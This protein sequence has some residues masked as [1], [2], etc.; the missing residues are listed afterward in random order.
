MANCVRSC[1]GNCHACCIDICLFA[2]WVNPQRIINRALQVQ[3][4]LSPLI[5]KGKINPIS[6]EERRGPPSPIFLETGSRCLSLLFFRLRGFQDRP[7]PPLNLLWDRR[8][9]HTSPFFSFRRNHQF[10]FFFSFSFD[11]RCIKGGVARRTDTATWEKSL[12]SFFLFTGVQKCLF[13]DLPNVGPRGKLLVRKSETFLR[14]A[15][16][17][18]RLRFPSFYVDEISQV[19]PPSQ[20]RVDLLVSNF[21]SGGEKKREKKSRDPPIFRVSLFSLFSLYSCWLT[22]PRFHCSSGNHWL[23]KLVLPSLLRFCGKTGLREKRSLSL[24]NGE[25][26]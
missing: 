14:S 8:R 6:L 3:L 22:S 4:V 24:G 9:R 16:S 17:H 1:R 15:F 10:P 7:P 23:R 2:F 21:S 20:Y 26:K 11:P 19:S 13:C 12:V 18:A 5:W 25:E